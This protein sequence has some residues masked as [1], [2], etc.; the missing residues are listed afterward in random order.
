MEKLQEQDFSLS[1]SS[2]LIQTI[3]SSTQNLLTIFNL[4]QE[5][6]SLLKLL[7]KDNL[8]NPNQW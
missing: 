7:L 3:F 1:L 2:R 4:S 6:S 8:F 5:N